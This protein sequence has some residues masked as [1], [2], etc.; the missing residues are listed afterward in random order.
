MWSIQL[1]PMLIV[2]GGD[3]ISMTG[4]MFL[5]KT[6]PGWDDSR[7]MAGPRL[8]VCTPRRS[9]KRSARVMWSGTYTH[10]QQ[11][12]EQP[13][14]Q[15]TNQPTKTNKQTN[16]QTTKQ[17]NNQTSQLFSVASLCFLFF[18]HPNLDPLGLV[19]AWQAPQWNP[20]SESFFVVTVSLLSYICGPPIVHGSFK[21][22]FQS[23]A[24]CVV[25]VYG[26]SDDESV[27][28]SAAWR[29]SQQR[30]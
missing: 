23:R 10:I 29:S 1:F 16:K 17:P 12:P 26:I 19:S 4:V 15:P 25:L 8:Q 30:W 28:G 14:N 22:L 6:G 3:T 7:G 18:P 21:H 13:T 24:R 2:R 27:C 5:F 9:R 11:R 20:R